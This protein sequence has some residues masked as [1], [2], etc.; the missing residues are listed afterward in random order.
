[1]PSLRHVQSLSIGAH[2]RTHAVDYFAIK[3]SAPGIYSMREVK[4]YAECHPYGVGVVQLSCTLH[5]ASIEGWGAIDHHSLLHWCWLPSVAAAHVGMTLQHKPHS[6]QPSGY[7]Q[8]FCWVETFPSVV[9]QK[10]WSDDILDF[11]P[12]TVKCYGKCCDFLPCGNSIGQHAAN[13]TW[14]G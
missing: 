5:A 9:T 13:V 7:Q 10:L 4:Q 12:E 6:L 8:N 2:H 1:M 14:S 3:S 11:R